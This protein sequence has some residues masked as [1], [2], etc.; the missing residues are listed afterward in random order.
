MTSTLSPEQR[1]ALLAAKLRALVAAH[2]DGPGA[3]SAAAESG[4][5]PGGATLRDGTRGWVLA[6]ADAP[7]VVGPAIAWARRHGVELEL[8][9]EGPGAATAAR[10]A[11]LF[12]APPRV[13]TVDGA[14]LV[15][16]APAAYPPPEGPLPPAVATLVTL[17]EARG[18][19][20]V[21]EGDL[22]VGEVLGLEVARVVVDDAGEHASL[23]VGVGRMDRELVAMLHEGVP[24][25]D[26]LATV[27]EVVRRHRHDTAEPH[28][29]NRLAPERWL[30]ARL[31]G[32]PGRIGL[33]SLAA[34]PSV[35][36]R[37]GLREPEAAAGIGRTADGRPVVVVCSV[38]I[39]LDAVPAA[40]EVHRWWTRT[41]GV[42]PAD[43]P[44][45]LVVP[46]RDAH[47]ATR[48]LAAALAV[49]AEVVTV[50]ST[51]RV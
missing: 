10:R 41:E 18:I 4:S 17:L 36:G 22:V 45:R 42:P 32:D 47:P 24:A 33:A 34:L 23:E 12:A 31:A 19:E 43:V 46:E 39:D 49:P 37:R 5:L 29:L 35:V 15:P 44:L 40:A 1:R 38:G 27:V 6:E 8:V 9:A 20:V 13:W 48:D 7:R 25:A 30:R 51:W 11:R 28:P 21:R 26:S 3:V 2:P 16:A 14:T 50:P